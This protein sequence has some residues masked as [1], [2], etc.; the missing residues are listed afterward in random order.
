MQPAELLNDFKKPT[1]Q[2]ALS[3]LITDPKELLTLLELSPTL[4]DAAMAAAQ[5]FP[6][7]IPRRFLMRIQKGNPNDPLLRQILPLGAELKIIQGY[8]KDPLRETNANPIPGLLHKYQ[9]RVLIT[10]TSAC[11]I[12]C[13]YCFRRH[14]SYRENNPGKK[15]W[16]KIFDYIKNNNAINEVI[17]SGGDPLAVSD[18]LL[19]LFSDQLSDISHVKRLR[20]HTRIPVVLPERITSD[21]IHW[22]NTL[23]LNLV[24]PAN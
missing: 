11:A 22:I 14:F 2:E 23:K 21:F 5:L 15:G 6:L 18:K 4:L 8:D 17:L 12:H 1:W 3:D 24:I 13:R 20:L 19:S 10:L 16:E 7:K 9:N